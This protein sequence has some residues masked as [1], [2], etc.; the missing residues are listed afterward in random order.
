MPDISM[1]EEINLT[2]LAPPPPLEEKER[3]I[4]EAK[5]AE[6]G[7]QLNIIKIVQDI[8]IGVIVVL[9]VGFAAAF[10][11]VGGMIV[12]YEAERKAVFENL[13]DQVTAQN[14]KMDLL[15]QEYGKK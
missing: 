15:I 11:A 2:P 14:A 5:P 4:A 8:V 7:G 9:L 12:N 3:A 1:P 6:Q 13:K 10:I